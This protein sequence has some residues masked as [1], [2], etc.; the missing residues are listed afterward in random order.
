MSTRGAERLTLRNGMSQL[1]GYIFCMLVSNTL[2]GMPLF[3]GALYLCG[4][5]ILVYGQIF[6]RNRRKYLPPYA[7][8]WGWVLAAMT[9]L[10]TVLLTGLYPA[11]FE[12]ASLWVVFAMAALNLAVEAVSR[13]GSRIGN[14]LNGRSLTAL[15]L[16]QIL[17]SGAAAWVLLANLGTVN[18]GL[19]AIGFTLRTLFQVYS[20]ITRGGS[21]EISESA[22]EEGE[23]IRTLPVFRSYEWVSVLLITAVEMGSV[24][25]YALLAT[26][27]DRLM[28]AM[29]VGIGTTIA[30][31]EIGYLLLKRSERKKYRDP[32][33]LLCI[34]LVLWLYGMIVCGRMLTHRVIQY[35]LIYFVLALCSMGGALS[36]TGLGRIEQLM[37]DVARMSNRPMPEGY[38]EIREINL[39]FARLLGD[40]LA[41]I[42]LTAICFGIG[43]DLPRDLG[44]LA[45]R[46]QPLMMIPLTLVG[47]VALLA[48]LRF[49]IG[50]RIIR[51]MRRFLHQ[52]EETGEE[53]PVLRREVEEALTGRYRQPFLAGILIAI[54]RPIYRHR[55]VG[56]EN[57]RTDDQNPLVFLCNH[58]EIYGPVVCELYMPVPIRSWAISLMMT[59]KK[60]V[61]DYLYEN[62]FAP[63]RFLPEFLKRRI[64]GFLG[65]MSVTVMRQVEAIPVYRDSPI[66]LRET[67]RKSIEGLQAGDNLLIFPEMPDGKYP[68]EGI[69]PLSP[70][71]V[72][73]AAAYWRKTKKRL[74]ILPA[75]ANR[76]QRTIT[77]GKEIVFNPDA[78]FA[79]EEERI[80]GEAEKQMM[81]MAGLKGSPEAEGSETA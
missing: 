19:L 13:L 47:F 9:A 64:S 62:T 22:V 39:A 1:Y 17:L 6:R 42:A 79:E 30:G 77:F 75:Y 69:A 51:K 11:S 10:I 78:P 65:W 73:L 18:G 8:K 16:I 14:R 68:R 40:G 53:N 46:F 27:A 37:P 3:G 74:R 2:T 15:I 58:G 44:A 24:M 54:L 48:V 34:G 28:T 43:K 29:A 35:E 32:T 55:L 45:A 21:T 60:E 61:S 38:S 25:I 67:I 76:H 49:P 57:I 80:V 4:K 23:D 72:M 59:D 33:G 7:R 63:K 26:N 31:V 56:T 12:S 5:L 81:K 36:L 20:D 41:L 70:G 50:E 66:K 52:Q 71:F